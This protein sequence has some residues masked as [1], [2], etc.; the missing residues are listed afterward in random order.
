[1]PD[2][3]R[4]PKDAAKISKRYLEDVIRVRVSS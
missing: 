4:T 3:A 1:V 2:H